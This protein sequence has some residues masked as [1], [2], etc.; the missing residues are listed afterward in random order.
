M[1]LLLVTPTIGKSQWLTQTQN[2]IRYVKS[3]GLDVF[4][5]IVCPETSKHKVEDSYEPDLVVAEPPG[6]GMY[7][8][9]NYAVESVKSIDWSHFS[10]INDDD[11]LAESFYEHCRYA[12]TSNQDVVYGHI[13]YV[14]IHSTVVGAISICKNTK[15]LL[16]LFAMGLAPFSQQGTILKKEIYNRIGG[17]DTSFTHVADCFMWIRSIEVGASFG[18]SG[19]KAACFRVR[20]GQLGGDMNLMIAQTNA[21]R[22]YIKKKFALNIFNCYIAFVRFKFTNLR[23][24]IQRIKRVGF[25]SSQ[26]YFRMGGKVLQVK[27]Q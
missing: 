2:S 25:H 5:I 14:D 4:W 26:A 3:K 20:P 27:K 7:V 22:Q 13:D 19:H 11:Y 6:G 1:K 15:D 23:T 9:I 8:A 12:E 17:F 18:Y 21:T 24:I 16:P 10:Y